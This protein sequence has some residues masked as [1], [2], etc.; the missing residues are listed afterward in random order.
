MLRVSILDKFYANV[1][2][3]EIYVK[4]VSNAKRYFLSNLNSSSSKQEVYVRNLCLAIILV[5]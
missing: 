1:E 5:S 3:L 4:F 2:D